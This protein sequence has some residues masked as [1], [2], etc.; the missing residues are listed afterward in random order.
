[1]KSYIH[2]SMMSFFKISA[3]TFRVVPNKCIF[4]VSKALAP[5]LWG[6]KKKNDVVFLRMDHVIFEWYYLVTIIL[7]PVVEYTL[8][9]VLPLIILI[10]S[11]P[12]FVCRYV[13]PRLR[14]RALIKIPAVEK[15]FIKLMSVKRK[16]WKQLFE[17]KIFASLTNYCSDKYGRNINKATKKVFFIWRP[18][19]IIKM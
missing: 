14:A 19:N 4:F 16:H 12:I 11:Q 10:Y 13:V 7:L 17:I 8:F 3:K 18:L 9:C 1:M 5:I 6:P 15:F 2:I